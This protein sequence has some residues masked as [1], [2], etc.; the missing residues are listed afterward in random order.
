[1]Q[2]AHAV[3]AQ[4]RQQRRAK[5]WTQ[6]QL[7][8]AAGLSVRMVQDAESGKRRPQP[9][10]LVALRS[11]LEIEGDPA[12]AKADWPLDVETFLYVMGAFLSS[13]PERDR[14]EV[15]REI[16]THIVGR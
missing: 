2:D 6:R 12:Q 9:Q 16:T 14:S 7:A 3:G 10:N 1:M 5:K 11:A 15:I 4:I 13:M 8:E